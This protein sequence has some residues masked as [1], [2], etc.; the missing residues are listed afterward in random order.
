MINVAQTP[1]FRRA[2]R[3]LVGIVLVLTTLRLA[4]ACGDRAGDSDT[5]VDAVAEV[6]SDAGRSDTRAD[7]G[8]DS[9]G[10][11]EDAAPDV[12]DV[13]SD[14]DVGDVEDGGI[15]VSEV[16]DD[17][18]EVGD[19]L[20]LDE[21]GTDAGDAVEE[22]DGRVDDVDDES[23][24]VVDVDGDSDASEPDL[25]AEADE[26]ESE[27]DVDWPHEC[28]PTPPSVEDEPGWW[29]GTTLPG[30]E[31][32]V[33]GPGFRLSVPSGVL[34]DGVEFLRVGQIRGLPAGYVAVSS[35]YYAGRVPGGVI[36]ETDLLAGSLLRAHVVPREEVADAVRGVVEVDEFFTGLRHLHE[37]PIRWVDDAAEFDIPSEWISSSDQV[38]VMFF[39]GYPQT[40]ICGDGIV[41]PIEQCDHGGSDCLDCQFV[42]PRCRPGEEACHR[43]CTARTWDGPYIDCS[44]EPVGPCEI[45]A[46][47]TYS[48]E[49]VRW[50]THEGEPCEDGAVSGRCRA[51]VCSPEP[52]ECGLCSRGYRFV[53]G[54]CWPEEHGLSFVAGRHLT[55]SMTPDG[56]EQFQSGWRGPRRGRG[57]TSSRIQGEV[58]LP[59]VSGTLARS[60]G[61][62]LTYESL[63]P[64][65]P[66]D[67]ADP[68]GPD[69]WAI[70][71]R[72]IPW[73]PSTVRLWFEYSGII[74]EFLE[75][76]VDL[77]LSS[78]IR[79]ESIELPEPR[80][81]DIERSWP[82]SFHWQNTGLASAFGGSFYVTRV[83]VAHTDLGVCDVA[84]NVD[85]EWRVCPER[86]GATVC[87][88]QC[89]DT[90]TNGENCGECGH[91]CG[92]AEICA[93]GE[94]VC[95]P[96]LARLDLPTCAWDACPEGWYG[97]GC[98]SVCAGVLEGEPQCNGN[99]EC[100]DGPFGTGVCVCDMF[101]HGPNCE[102]RCDDRIR[103]G[104]E[105]NVDCGGTQC[106][107]C[108]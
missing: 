79:T 35:V 3:R 54:A 84:V 46:C 72:A 65:G 29:V 47:D 104:S 32:E 6:G 58:A 60:E 4:G 52:E 56:V 64:T 92:D 75:M 61:D 48:T 99:G 41:D 38:Y 50:P 11:A 82:Q 59:F 80:V 68:S 49:C 28:E 103:N 27:L 63:V 30:G 44:S 71:Y 108:E 96:R 42:D 87:D 105:V 2:R 40:T 7:A 36:R 94:C 21:D 24:D 20:D 34:D 31:H 13:R 85:G 70:E 15:D 100:S 69:I 18:P 53:D 74:D 88:G 43:T 77:P 19:E 89:I 10:L 55:P 106:W 62:R 81:Y 51:G 22:D 66:R 39:L 76:D 1:L 83:R 45:A 9:T 25:D 90:R 5:S 8:V 101:T 86:P 73:S 16:G 37:A 97:P 14:L 91:A 26:T 23:A 107:P 57:D 12:R 33:C 67:R 98:R 93:G 78:E 102:F 17:P 95:D